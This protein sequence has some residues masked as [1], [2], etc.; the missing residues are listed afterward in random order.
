MYTSVSS[1]DISGAY[2]VIGLTTW[3][4]TNV[5]W[6]RAMCELVCPLFSIVKQ[7]EWQCMSEWVVS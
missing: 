2:F 5:V 7:C 6:S 4:A 3:T 1:Y